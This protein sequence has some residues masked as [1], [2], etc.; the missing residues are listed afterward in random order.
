H[1]VILTIEELPYDS[2]SVLICEGYQSP[3]STYYWT[4]SGHYIDTIPSPQNCDSIIYIDL[5]ILQASLYAIEVTD[6]NG[7]FSSDGVNFWNAT[8]E[9]YE[10]YTNDQGCDSIVVTFLEV[11]E[12]QI[13]I[14]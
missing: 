5:E 13:S 4:E 11:P 9:Y 14:D 7:I 6:C 1:Q 12:P 2:I 8:G 3:S 10:Y